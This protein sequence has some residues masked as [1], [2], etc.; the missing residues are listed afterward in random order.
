MDSPWKSKWLPLARIVL[1][2][3]LGGVFIY[4]SW[5]K[6]A[7]PAEFAGLVANYQLLPRVL[8]NPT[9]L[10][11]PWLEL[12]CGLALVSGLM[13]RGSALIVAGLLTVFI[14]ALTISLVRG[15]DIQCGC[16]SS[17][18]QGK[19][20]MYL[21]IGLDLVLLVLALAVLLLP[22]RTKRIGISSYATQA[23]EATKR[24]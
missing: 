1:R 15:L 8:V 23:P 14:G 13:A 18:G 21:D 20:N 16:F 19:I 5:H 22:S 2:I 11:L 12:M 24:R 7:R 3:L 6:I 9:A 10:L 4:A 17:S